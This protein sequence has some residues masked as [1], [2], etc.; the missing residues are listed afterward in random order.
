MQRS[1]TGLN[2]NL[3]SLSDS[4]EDFFRNRGLSPQLTETADERTIICYLGP[5]GIRINDPMS[6]R[7]IGKSSDFTIDVEASELMDRSIHVGI[8]TKLFG[9]GYFLLR[10][11]KLR[12]ELEKLEKEFWIYIEEKIAQ[13]AEST[14][15]E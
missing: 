1:W 9:G 13:L 14:R 11:V 2:V 15:K 4:V 7:I 8:L 5:M 6:V 12:E 3:D 10:A